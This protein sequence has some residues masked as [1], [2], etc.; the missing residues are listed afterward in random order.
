MANPAFEKTDFTSLL[1]TFVI[2]AISAIFAYYFVFFLSNYVVIFFAY[3]FDIPASFSIKGI[4]FLTDSIDHPWSRDAI[5]TVLLS[6]A[7][8]AFILGVILLFVL[9][10]RTKKPSAIILLLFWL[11]VFAFSSSFGELLDDIINKTGIYKAV[12]SMNIDIAY[13]IIMAIIL[14]FFLYKIGMMNGKIIK[15]YF[16]IQIFS[17]L[18]SRV[19]FFFSIL[20][21]PWLLEASVTH[22]FG[23][24]SFSISEVLKNLPV[25]ILLIPFF[26]KEKV[27]DLNTKY[28]LSDRF[29]AFNW[30]I[31]VLL[32]IISISLILLMRNEIIISG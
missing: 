12:N 16:A 30:I 4:S 25:L 29:L 5:I 10:I 31:T 21:I 7:I 3:D 28:V 24:N 20:I 13:L 8:F 22:Y 15:Q 17:S 2:S 9:M 26:S 23:G 27:E 19:I 6:K 32:M 11:N 14:A 1:K 18:Q